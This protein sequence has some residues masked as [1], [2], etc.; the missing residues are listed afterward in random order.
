[1]KRLVIVAEMPDAAGNALAYEDGRLLWA[2]SLDLW[3]EMALSTALKCD[4]EDD[5]VPWAADVKR[6]FGFGAEDAENAFNVTEVRI[7]DMDGPEKEP[8]PVEL[9]AAEWA[10]LAEVAR[11][12]G[13]TP[14]GCFTRLVREWLAEVGAK[15]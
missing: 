15:V 12:S 7:E 10:K 8:V 14:K 11:A 13:E 3:A 1:M 9:D 6:L 2:E 5:D 4:C